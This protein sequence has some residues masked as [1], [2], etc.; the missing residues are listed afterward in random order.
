MSTETQSSEK[1]PEDFTRTW[2][3]KVGLFM[4][5]VGNGVIVLGLFLPALGF[6]ASVVGAS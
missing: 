6:G 5:I 2:R 3:Y 4:I 1:A